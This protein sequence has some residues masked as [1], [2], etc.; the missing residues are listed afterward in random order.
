[1]YYI[2][3]SQIAANEWVTGGHCA[4]LWDMLP[5]VTREHLTEEEHAHIINKMV[6][7]SIAPRETI[8]EAL[9]RNDYNHVTATYFLLA[10]RKLRAQRHAMARK[11]NNNKSGR[12]KERSKAEAKAAAPPPTPASQADLSTL[13]LTS[14]LA[15]SP[16][17][18][19]QPGAWCWPGWRLTTCSTQS[20]P[21][22]LSTTWEVTRPPLLTTTTT[23][24]LQPSR[25]TRL[26][27]A[28]LTLSTTVAS[29]SRT[30]ARL[31]RS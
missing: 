25:D 22:K 14:S 7:G 2:V 29:P 23:T 8:I 27:M 21:T 4:P 17:R 15:S 3:L 13:S 28:R 11:V 6:A 1:M 18:A 19:L 26:A 9:D 30:R 24:R 12:S 10:E 5:L 16:W 20:S 31:D